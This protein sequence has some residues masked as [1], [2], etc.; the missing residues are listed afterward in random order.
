MA[1]LIEDLLDL[2]RISRSDMKKEEVGLSAHV[3]KIMEDLNHAHPE[4][5]V[6]W[7]V[8]PH[9]KAHGDVHLLHIALENLLSNAWKFTQQSAQPKN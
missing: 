8:A 7:S 3:Q 2:S 1:Q 6:A 4:R 5:N 9:L